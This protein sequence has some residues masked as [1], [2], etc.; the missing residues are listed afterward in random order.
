M[1]SHVTLVGN[2]TRDPELK[3]AN[4]GMPITKFSLAVNKKNKAGEES[5]SFFDVTTF[6]SLA[7]NVAN[8][9]RAGHRVIVAGN[10]EVRQYEGNDGV[11]KTAVGVIADAVG[12][13]MR[14]A[15]TTVSKTAA[16]MRTPSMPYSVATEEE[17]F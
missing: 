14:F 12:A 15:T 1:S 7:E 3:F 8:C 17:A 10:L 2:V 16:P 13:E 11:K 6:G 5:V 9:T 4:S